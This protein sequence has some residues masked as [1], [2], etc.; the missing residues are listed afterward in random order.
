VFSVRSKQVRK[1]LLDLGIAMLGGT[2]GG[3]SSIRIR[4]KHDRELVSN[5]FTLNNI[6]VRID[7]FA[8]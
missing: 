6:G 5:Y 4:G 3:Y 7:G 1:D 8:Q 2:T